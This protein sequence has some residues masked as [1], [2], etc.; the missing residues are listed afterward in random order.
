VSRTGRRGFCRA[1]GALACVGVGGCKIEPILGLESEP[2]PLSPSYPD[3]PPQIPDQ[4]ED[5]ETT[6]RAL[7]EKVLEHEIPL[8]TSGGLAERPSE[9]PAAVAHLVDLMRS[10]GLAPA[11]NRGGWLQPVMLDIV[12]PTGETPTIVLRPETEA[13]AS[14][15]PSSSAT[16]AGPNQPATPASPAGVEPP[17]PSRAVE[18]RELGAFRQRGAAV[19]HQS[20]LVGS[21]RDYRTPLSS[22]AVAGRIAVFRAPAE[23]SLDDGDA[24]A[25]VDSLMASV[26]DAGALGCLLLTDD[27]GPALERFRTIW[28]RQVRRA[29]SD[30]QAMLI[31]GVL[32]KQGRERLGQ[33]LR[34]DET[35]AL[36]VDLATR[37]YQ[38]ETHNILGRVTG[39]ERPD[40]AIVLTCAWD[41]P[42]PM[43]AEIDSIRLLTSLAAFYQLAE[44]SRR[45]SPPRYSLVLLLTAD[46][47]F[48]AGQSV[49]AA[50]SATYG[51]ETKA[52]LALDRPTTRP[53]PAVEL[54]GHY[55]A[56]TAE[57]ARR[58]VAADGRD[59]LLA[60]QLA[61]PSLAPYLRYPAPVMT[62]GAPRP[63]AIEEHGLEVTDEEADGPRMQQSDG[64]LA[65]LYTDVR[66][67]RNLI[68]ALAARR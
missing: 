28:Q 33:L 25:H 50:W 12:E 67:L 43:M 63:E 17:P 47:G 32:G 42:D 64:P 7:T 38:V 53:L 54:S 29:G 3:L 45:S 44:W 48:A 30:E 39:R 8:L 58:V 46:A 1:L 55:D 10:F 40:E 62:I 23:L 36:D 65:G 26:R 52:M 31:E 41:T 60:D 56:A 14:K 68:L 2:I 18:L 57:L 34:G 5:A 49:H 21:I 4:L 6:L 66:L 13:P 22:E 16:P 35:W 15:L 61:M 59:L 11:G 9:D 20:L 19:P 27:E 37:S 51:A 24:P